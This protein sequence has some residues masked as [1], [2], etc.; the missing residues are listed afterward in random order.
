VS[1]AQEV[2]DFGLGVLSLAVPCVRIA[3]GTFSPN[4]LN[5]VMV[6]VMVFEGIEVDLQV[7]LVLWQAGFD[8]VEFSRYNLDKVE[9]GAVYWVGIW[10]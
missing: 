2:V 6:D 9:S 10:E 3:N 4:G 1:I 5:H 8:I 7:L